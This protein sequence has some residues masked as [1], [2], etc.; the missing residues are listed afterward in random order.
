MRVGTWQLLLYIC[1]AQLLD[2]CNMS[3]LQVGM[4][5]EHGPKEPTLR[6]AGPAAEMVLHVLAS[7]SKMIIGAVFV[8]F[9]AISVY[10]LICGVPRKAPQDAS[11]KAGCS[12]S[13]FI[14]LCL[15]YTFIWFTTDQ[16]VPSLPQMEKD[17]SGSE[18]IMSA[19]VQLNF[20]V[21]SL[22]GLVTAG[23]SDRIGRKPAVLACHLDESH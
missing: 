23:I 19:S 18:T 4:Q 2:D 7:M 21:K 10:W 20:I 1:R 6:F 11:V 17:L 13:W 22:A 16:Y 15:V 9:L 14:F 3:F 12:T 5:V 8:L